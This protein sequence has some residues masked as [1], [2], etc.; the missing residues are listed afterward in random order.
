ME[1]KQRRDPYKH[2]R[3]GERWKREE[4]E[5]VLSDWEVS[6]ESLRGFARRRRLKV[7]RL[8]WWRVRL[9]E[10]AATAP[11]PLQ[12]IP[13][14]PE[15]A[16]LIPVDNQGGCSSVYVDVGVARIGVGDPQQTDPRWVAALVLELC[17]GGQ[18]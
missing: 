4:A 13:V 5:Q 18:S 10:L 8:Q 6:G 7:H 11:E 1:R 16:P 15:R 3:T 2:L 17:R 9:T 14:V 12:L